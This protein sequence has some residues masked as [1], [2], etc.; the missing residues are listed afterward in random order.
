MMTGPARCP[1]AMYAGGAF[2]RVGTLPCSGLARW[3]GVAWAAITPP[4][5]SIGP[6][7]VWTLDADGT[8][9]MYASAGDGYTIPS[10]LWRRRWGRMDANRQESRPAVLHQQHRRVRCGWVRSRRGH[11][12][13]HRQVPP[14][15][16]RSPV[17]K[18]RHGPRS[19]R[20]L[21]YPTAPRASAHSPSLTPT[22]P[23]RTPRCLSWAG[24][25]TTSARCRS[26]ASLSSTDKSGRTFTEACR[27]PQAFTRTSCLSRQSP[28]IRAA[29][30]RSTWAGISPEPARWP[31][32]V[33][34]DSPL[35]S[36]GRRNKG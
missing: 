16:Q 7:R 33:S 29:A 12:L 10:N 21:P 15:R 25:C 23:V 6:W 27:P 31:P 9:S 19:R 34:R 8:E 22:G 30:K 26:T 24:A 32:R 35:G 1:P 28:T 2:D 4:D 36:G 11:S 18:G 17:S 5:G 14:P 20:A 3:N 13:C